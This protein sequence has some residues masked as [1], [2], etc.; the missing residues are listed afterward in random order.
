MYARPFLPCYFCVCF[1][2]IKLW[3]KENHFFEMHDTAIMMLFVC[4]VRCW[5][6]I[7][8]SLLLRNCE[9][10][11]LTFCD[12]SRTVISHAFASSENWLMKSGI[13]I[14][15]H[16]SSAYCCVVSISSRCYYF[17]ALPICIES[18][19]RCSYLTNDLAN[20]RKDFH[21]EL[22]FLVPFQNKCNVEIATGDCR[23]CR[24]SNVPFE[25][26]AVLWL[27]DVTR[28]RYNRQHQFIYLIFR[29]WVLVCH[30]E[31]YLLFIHKFACFCHLCAAKG[32]EIQIPNWRRTLR[33]YR[34]VYQLGTNRRQKAN[35]FRFSLAASCH[36]LAANWIDWRIRKLK[37]KIKKKKWRAMPL[38]A[39]IG[40]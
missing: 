5:F 27:L 36:T 4:Y 14:I 1:L 31:L 28:V 29:S 20:F 23:H 37:Q 8:F 35:V 15:K 26:G 22:S 32:I 2:F 10:L 40:K 11:G 30:S 17:F 33:Y 18:F 19:E 38:S 25:C 39:W 21:D 16:F 7:F 24:R 6:C 3:W 13:K 9:Q 34:T 12:L